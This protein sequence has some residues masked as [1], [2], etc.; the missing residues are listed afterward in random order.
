MPNSKGSDYPSAYNTINIRSRKPKSLTEWAS[1]IFQCFDMRYAMNPV[2]VWTV[3]NLIQWDQMYC[4]I[5]VK[6]SGNL[7]TNGTTND[8]NNESIINNGL[9]YMLLERIRILSI[10]HMWP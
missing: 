3:F 2:L 9:T 4:Y 10:C 6:R 1:Y 8:A 5:Y 7:I